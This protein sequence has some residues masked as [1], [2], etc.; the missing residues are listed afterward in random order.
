MKSLTS[1][2]RLVGTG[3]LLYFVYFETGIFTVIILG[4]ICLYIEL[5]KP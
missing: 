1:I 4:L 5:S 3:F 2:L